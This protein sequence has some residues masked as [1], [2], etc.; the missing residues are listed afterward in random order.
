M[1]IEDF[2]DA[3]LGALSI[4]PIQVEEDDAADGILEDGYSEESQRIARYLMMLCKPEGMSRA[5]FRAFKRR[6]L[7]YAVMDK[8]L[9]FTGSKNIPSRIVVDLLKK[10][11]QILKELHDECGHKGRES[12][13]RKVA[14]RYYWETCYQDTKAFIASCKRCQ[15]RDPRRQEEALHPTWTSVMFEKIGLDVVHMPSCNGKNYLVIARDDLSG[16]LEARALASATSEAVAKFIW[17]DIMCCH[18]C[19]SHLVIDGGLENK[20]HVAEFVKWYGIDH[21]QVSAYHPQANGMVEQGHKPIVEALSCMMDGGIGNW[22][23]N[24]PAVLLAEWTMVHQPTGQMPFYVVYG[25][26][27]VLPVEL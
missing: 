20:K 21:V 22:V 27:A 4:A 9:Y 10:R 13:Y 3:E 25:R 24:L 23:T 15:F 8:Q 5:E 18:G 6:A 1:D 16:W 19:F 26:E 14:N 2:I 11:T 7:W 17:E 12:T